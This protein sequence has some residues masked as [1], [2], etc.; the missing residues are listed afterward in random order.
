MELMVTL[1][2]LQLVI[3]PLYL[4]F[5]GSRKMMINARELS[6][7]VS[8]G[9]SMIA[10]LRKM[11]IRKVGELSATSEG[12]LTGALSLENLGL[13]KVPD[14]FHRNL[15]IKQLDPTG[16]GGGP[17]YEAVVEIRWKYSKLPNAPELKIAIKG[18]LGE[19]ES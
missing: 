19:K 12:N 14:G 6:N 1:F 13:V 4:V 5:S 2:I 3:A 16:Q 17:F 7:A 11:D 9:S 8:F 18:L 10:G 15:T